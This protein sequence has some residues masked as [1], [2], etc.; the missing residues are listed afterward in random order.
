MQEKVTVFETD[1]ISIW[2]HSDTKILHHEMHKPTY[3][4]ALQEALLKGVETLAARK[5]S[6]WLSDDR[7]N[8][9]LPPEDLKWGDEVW[10]PMALKAGWK[11]WALVQPEKVVGQMN[12]RRIV[13][14]Y[15]D[16][17]ITANIFTEPVEA[18]TWLKSL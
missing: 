13:K 16:R 15:A 8:S 2:W 7:K 17:G 9:A 6:K 4:A 10:I 14:M 12:M 3:G 1:R 11:Y 18:M 5:G